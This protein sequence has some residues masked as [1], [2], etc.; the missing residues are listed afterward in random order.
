MG[1]G[2]IE[3]FLRRSVSLDINGKVFAYLGDGEGIPLG[4]ELAA[5]IQ[6]YFFD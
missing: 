4:L 5:G 3:H 1:G 6:V 2:G